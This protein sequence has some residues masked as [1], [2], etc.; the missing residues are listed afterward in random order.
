MSHA[1]TR[2]EASLEFD[3]VSKWYKQVSALIDIGF[4]IGPGVTGLVG[5]NGAGKST[6]LKLASGLLRPSLGEV[7]LCGGDPQR[8]AVR[9]SIGVCPDLDRFYENLSGVVF[10]SWMLRLQG[11]GAR[12]A[13]RRA[14]ELL[15]ELGLGDAMHR[16]IAGYSKGMRQ[17]VK[18]AQALAHDPSV[19]VMDEP[20]TGLDPIARHELGERIRAMGQ[21]GVAVL[22]SS[23][24]LH[25]LQSVADHFVLV[26][27]GRLVAEG[28]LRELRDQLADRPR[29]LTLKTEDPR[30]L[31]RLVCALPQVSGLRIEDGEVGVEVR[32]AGLFEELTRIGAEA[33][34]VDELVVRDD[35]LE[36][37]FG[38]LVP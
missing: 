25:E 24:V 20:L 33:G 2:T 5:Q 30:A 21:R 16:R 14:T 12:A 32:G 10:V 11:F 9:R 17:R 36:A 31:A 18:L 29:Q 3:H 35:S 28:G 4:R 38:Y 1:E 37:V 6:L 27:Q 7:R 15:G 26:H 8:P 23:H 19:V 34:L 22:V 13:R